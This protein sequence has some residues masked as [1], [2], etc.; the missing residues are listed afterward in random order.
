[1]DVDRWIIESMEWR[2]HQQRI[3]PTHIVHPMNRTEQNTEHHT[4]IIQSIFLE[5]INSSFDHNHILTSYLLFKYLKQGVWKRS[6]F[7]YCPSG[8]GA[9][10]LFDN[11]KPEEV[12]WLQVSGRSDYNYQGGVKTKI[13][14]VYSSPS[15]PIC[16]NR[17]LPSNSVY[18]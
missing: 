16:S 18:L 1:M 8:S 4:A 11:G 9:D 15:S 14:G 6:M 12:K 5:G 7:N 13:D 10:V 2:L 3:E 17:D